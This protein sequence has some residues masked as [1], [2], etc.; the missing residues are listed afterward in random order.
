MRVTLNVLILVDHL[1]RPVFKTEADDYA[2]HSS[3]AACL[4]VPA[5]RAVGKVDVHA[6]RQQPAPEHAD[7][8]ALGDAVGGDKG[9]ARQHRF[10]SG[11]MHRL[12][13]T[14]RLDIPR[15]YKIQQSRVA[16]AG[17]HGAGVFALRVVHEL[18]AHERRI[19]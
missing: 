13:V 18:G 3:F 8:F 14:R 6:L 15:R 11:S 12:Y 1:A 16:D 4:V 5:E 17:E 2:M 9:G 10:N 7:L 19:A